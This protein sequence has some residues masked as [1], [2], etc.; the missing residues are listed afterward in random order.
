MSIC[1]FLVLLPLS[2]ETYPKNI[3]KIDAKEVIAYVLF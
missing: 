3:T 2:E 1:L